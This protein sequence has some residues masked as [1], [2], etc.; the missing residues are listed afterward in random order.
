MPNWVETSRLHGCI[1]VLF[2]IAMV[3]WV[4]EIMPSKWR[5]AIGTYDGTR[6]GLRR[7]VQK[8]RAMI[9]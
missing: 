4:I 7:D 9:I 1:M 8:Q 5:S 3:K 6:N 2:L